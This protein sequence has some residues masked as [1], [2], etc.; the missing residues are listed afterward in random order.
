MLFF[1]FAA[2]FRILLNLADS[3][4]SVTATKSVMLMSTNITVDVQWLVTILEIPVGATLIFYDKMIGNVCYQKFQ[5]KT[6]F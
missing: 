5:V 1:I 4:C 6:K 2:K 3:Y